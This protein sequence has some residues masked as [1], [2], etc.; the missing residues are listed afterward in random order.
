MKKVNGRLKRELQAAKDRKLEQ[1]TR[2]VGYRWQS[3]TGLYSIIHMRD[4]KE[5]YDYFVQQMSPVVYRMMRLGVWST[6]EYTVSIGKT[7]FCGCISF[8][9]SKEEPKTCKHVKCLMTLI[10]PDK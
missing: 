10:K 2:K 8:Q 1:D 7:K 9:K 6:S 4:E 5:E 3:I